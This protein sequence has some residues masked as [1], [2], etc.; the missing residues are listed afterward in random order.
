MKKFRSPISLL[1]VLLGLLS[2]CGTDDPSPPD[3]S[4]IQIETVSAELEPIGFDDAV[5]LDAEVTD[6]LDR[7]TEDGLRELEAEILAQ[8]DPGSEVVYYR[9]TGTF[10]SPDLPDLRGTLTSLVIAVDGAAPYIYE[11]RVPLTQV[12]CDQ[13]ALRWTQMDTSAAIETDKV[14]AR[15]A[16]MGYLTMENEDG[17]AQDSNT[18]YPAFTVSLPA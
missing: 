17:S 5:Q 2:A 8:A 7:Y 6:T 9:I 14:S 3:L 12:L 18:I 16:G 13:P 4:N 11:V 15:I 10:S 1:L